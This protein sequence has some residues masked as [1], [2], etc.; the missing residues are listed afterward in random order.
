MTEGRTSEA[1]KMA[2]WFA[3]GCVVLSR[4]SLAPC[5]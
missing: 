5:S 4:S 3:G 2:T 1:C